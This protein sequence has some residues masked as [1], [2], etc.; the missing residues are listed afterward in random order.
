[1]QADVDG[2]VMVFD[3]GMDRTKQ[4]EKTTSPWSLPEIS[5]DSSDTLYDGER[6]CLKVKGVLRSIS[7]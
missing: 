5:P 6:E 1:M 2:K 7:S 3:Q 4:N